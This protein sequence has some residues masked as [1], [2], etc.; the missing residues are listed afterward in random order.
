[1]ETAAQLSRVSASECWPTLHI[2]GFKKVKVQPQSQPCY[3]F[4]STRHLL[5]AGLSHGCWTHSHHWKLRQQSQRLSRRQ[6]ARMGGRLSR[7]WRALGLI[8]PQQTWPAALKVITYENILR[9]FGAESWWFYWSFWL[10]PGVIPNGGFLK[11]KVRVTMAFNTESWS[12]M[13]RYPYF[14]KKPMEV[15]WN[16][17]SPQYNHPWYLIGSSVVTHPFWVPPCMEPPTS[18]N[19]TPIA[20]CFLWGKIP[21][22]N[23]WW[24]GK[25]LVQGNYGKLQLGWPEEIWAWDVD[26]CDLLGNG[27]VYFRKTPHGDGSNPMVPSWA[28]PMTNWAPPRCNGAGWPCA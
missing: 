21:S 2:E 19:E 23:G 24:L 5:C 4:P 12:S 15:S 6:G 18:R 26:P 3:F 27:G 25:P 1:M 9:F 13:T 14:R 16:G 28:S 10:V 17:G 8:R 7:T 11:W 20:G 22:R